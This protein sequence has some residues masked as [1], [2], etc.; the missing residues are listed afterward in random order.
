MSVEF[1]ERIANPHAPPLDFDN[2]RRLKSAVDLR[3][4][5]VD[6]ADADVKLMEEAFRIRG[7]IRAWAPHVLDE[8]DKCFVKRYI[9][10]NKQPIPSLFFPES[11]DNVNIFISYCADVDEVLRMH[12]ESAPKFAREYFS[13][14]SIWQIRGWSFPIPLGTAS[15]VDTLNKMCLG[16]RRGFIEASP[17]HP[18][19]HPPHDPFR[20]SL[21]LTV[22]TFRPYPGSPPPSPGLP[23][24]IQKCM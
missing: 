14:Y 19:F 22:P 4:G 7:D 21:S 3:E 16:V 6:P 8:I 24:S 1:L 12:S 11:V 18:L 10:D 5:E 15:V 2:I 9:G 23:G 17:F 20:P 13:Y